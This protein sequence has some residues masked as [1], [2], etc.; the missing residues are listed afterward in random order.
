ML[1]M[2]TVASVLHKQI[3]EHRTHKIVAGDINHTFLRNVSR[4]VINPQ[5][6]V[7]EATIFSASGLFLVCQEVPGNHTVLK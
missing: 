7:C 3:P 1:P 5:F 4:S 6:G 2:V